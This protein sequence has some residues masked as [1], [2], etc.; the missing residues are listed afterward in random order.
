MSLIKTK[1]GYYSELAQRSFKDY[2]I[3]DSELPFYTEGVYVYNIYDVCL[4]PTETF[5]PCGS[6]SFISVE[7]AQAR[8]QWLYGFF[9]QIGTENDYEGAAY[10]VAYSRKAAK[11]PSQ[12]E[13]ILCALRDIKRQIRKA[14]NKPIIDRI[15]AK[16][17][18]LT[19][20]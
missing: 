19:L 9:Y 14:P 17:Q 20:F 4:N 12:D 7:T 15:L 16:S 6:R 13:A 5:F 10:P 11:L 2:N 1:N 3:G 18:Q 8:G